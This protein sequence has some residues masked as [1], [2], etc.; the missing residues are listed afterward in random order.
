MAQSV[1]QRNLF[2]AEDYR[3]VYDSF[4]QANF[5]A[6]DYD[7]IRGALIDYIQ[8][9]YPENF[10][11]WIQSSEFVAL[12]ETLSFLAHSLAFRIDQAGRENFLSTAE[13]RA[14]VLRIADFLGYTPSRHQPARGNLKVTSIRTTQNVFDINGT[15]LKNKT[16]DF[17]DSFQ[18]FLLINNE[19]LSSTNKFGRP[20][21]S[22]KI[23]AVKTD[24]YQTNITS[25]RDVVFAFNGDVNGVRRNF[26]VHGLRIDNTTNTLQE[27]APD[28]N[29]SFDL[30]YRN[31]GQGLGSEN[32][33]FFV[34]FKQGNLQF[35]DINADSAIADLII[36]LGATDINDSD[37]WVQEIDTAGEIQDSWT[38]VNSSFGANTV[39]NNIKQDNRKLYSVKT[40]DND[41]AHIVFGDGVFS[42]IPRGIMRIWYRTGAN[43]SYTLD[44]ADL[45]VVNFSFDYNASDG[46][47][48]KVTYGCELQ[49]PVDNAASQESVTSIKQNA[50]RV[51]AT[52]D[53]MITAADYSVYPLTVSENVQKIKAINRTYVGHSRFIKPQD[54]TGQYQS[55]DMLARDGYVYTEGVL[56]RNTVD[57]PT[58]LTS[59]QIFERFVDDAIKNPEVV[60]LFYT[61]YSEENV[62]FD[63]EASSFEWQQ[64]TAGYRGSTGY[65]TSNGVIQKSGD[66]ATNALNTAR[67]GSIVEFVET[68][69]NAGTL[70]AIG[71]TL[72]IANAGSGFTSAPTVVIKG[73]GTGAA[74]TATIAAG[75]LAAVTITNGGTGY[76]NPV[77]IEIVGGS[78]TDAEVL[79]QASSATR[80]WARIVEIS[81]DGQ[82]IND[83][84]GNATGLTSRGQGAIILN[85]NIPNTARISRI[86]PAY[87]TVFSDS[88]RADIIDEITNRNTF[89]LRF[90]AANSKWIIVAAGDITTSALD[91]PDN[92]SFA[93][94]GNTSNSNLDASWIIRMNYV[95]NA[96]TIISRRDRFVFGS[97][98]A[99]RFY[100]QNGKRK[101]NV[102]TGKPERDKITVSG[103][104]TQP[105]GSVY[106]IGDDLAFYA[107]RYYTESDGYTDDHKVIVTLAD[108][109][110]DNYPDNPVAF[111][112]LVGA[113][114]IN[115]G[116][117]T[118][119]GFNYT[120]R[121]DT[122]TSAVG[123]ETLTF[124]WRRVSSSNYRIDPSL[125]NIIDVFVLNQNY[126]TKYKEWVTDGRSVSIRPEPPTEIQLKRQFASIATKKAISDSI[127][128]RAAEYKV[129][130]GELADVELQGRFKIVK[131]AGTTLT[132]NEIKSRVLTAINE[133]LEIDNWDFGEIFYFTELSAYIHQKLPGIVSS[134]VIVPV[135]SNSVF[136][137]LFQIIP[138][139]NELF[140]PDVTLSDIDLVDTLNAL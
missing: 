48:Y 109:D 60:N 43:Q 110:N 129:I 83:S 32:T 135:Q 92:F 70:G 56:Y 2:A 121:A 40:V 12:I 17:E 138:E 24:V 95:A 10:N 20:T 122:G 46:N 131:V 62:S 34:G 116:T 78:G 82:G 55:V 72:T 64:V 71:E 31:D 132:D 115:L 119:D 9:Q 79:A 127:V 53:R 120:V 1:R 111:K 93:N 27:T 101:F 25:G 41:N 15:T 96:W 30:V 89:G 33:G 90:D 104:N 136:G 73:T 8:Q 49:I 105:G 13:R 123:R 66:A 16:V 45:G 57:L 134:V 133:F 84:N 112:D 130:F 117:I 76:Q 38:K 37:V 28:P 50:G 63:V 59:E 42:E 75:Q 108:I 113:D 100:N 140:I 7:T 137:D 69:Y 102:E 51:F 107:Y 94:A 52:Q 11:D 3:V 81:D 67:A 22:T 47:V 97:D 44:P 98:S 124:V 21:N 126:D 85:K 88:E 139:S 14:S 5:Q 106:A 103:I 99:I 86:F 36:D 128:Y 125:S 35:N 114:T 29:A 6:Y 91:N 118:E 26:E 58:T 23:G 80:S 54:P 74:A 18:N 87:K 19:V 61:K 65:L 77:I 68:P 4:K 39:F